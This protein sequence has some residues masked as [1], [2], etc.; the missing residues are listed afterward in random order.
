MLKVALSH[1]IDRTKKTYQFFTKPLRNLLKGNYT[2]TINL[3][4]TIPKKNNYWTFDKILRIENQ[5]KV[6]S[7]YFFLNET[8]PLNL[9]DPKS[10]YL[11]LG[12]YK[13]ENE[14][15]K[16][17]I[18]KL[19]KE[20]FE[21]GVHGSFNSYNSIELLKEEKRILETILDHQVYGI[22]QHHLNLNKQTWQYQNDAGFIYDSSFG[23]NFEIGFKENKITPF[24]P[25]NN[26]FLVLPQVIMDTCF[27]NDPNRWEK[28]ELIIHQ[29]KNNDGVLVVNFHNHVFN[30]L[31]YPGY[32]EAYIRIIEKCKAHN[33]IFE[34]LSVYYNEYI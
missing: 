27:M 24:K 1:D 15:I 3:V 13:I 8:I 17:L 33:A 23:S 20:G 18:L 31:E 29:C 6:K 30:D 14:K 5:Y 34:T 4:K 28:L 21:V 22:R 32:T 25:L 19:D 26:Q 10:Y 2:N 9:F 11:S 7:T 16:S 12:R